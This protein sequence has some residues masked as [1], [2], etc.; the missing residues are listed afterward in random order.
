MTIMEDFSKIKKASYKNI[1]VVG[2]GLDLRVFLISTKCNEM[3]K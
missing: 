3:S 1:Y 2:H